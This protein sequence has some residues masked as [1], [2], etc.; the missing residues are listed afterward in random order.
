M[1]RSLIGVVIFI[2]LVSVWRLLPR[3]RPF[4]TD[5][6]DNPIL[7][8]RT[9]PYSMF[10]CALAFLGAGTYEWFVPLNHH[11]SGNLLILCYIPVAIGILALGMCL[12]FFTFLATLHKNKIE[13]SRWP[14]G[15]ARFD[16]ADLGAV[17]SKG[18]RTVLVFSGNR[19]FFVYPKYS[20]RAHFIS[21]LKR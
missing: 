8:Y 5:S 9:E 20:G 15:V 6:N 17:E 2:S 1:I 14:L 4:E 12:Y 7:R 11:Y 10:I 16:L 3:A 18:Q 21:A 13:L 19:R